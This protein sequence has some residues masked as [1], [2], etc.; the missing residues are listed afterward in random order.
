MQVSQIL[1]DV[2]T[3][4]FAGTTLLG[5]MW[6]YDWV[7]KRNSGLGWVPDRYLPLWSVTVE[8]GGFALSYFFWVKAPREELLDDLVV[9]FSSTLVVLLA[10]VFAVSIWH[11][12]LEVTEP[13]HYLTG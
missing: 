4:T 3:S 8:S 11:T 9:G 12:W 5:L 1:V 13:E 7:N 10:T 6:C 2:L